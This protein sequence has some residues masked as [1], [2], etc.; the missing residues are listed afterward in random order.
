MNP[1]NEY[2]WKRIYA[3]PDVA[4]KD[5][6]RYLALQKLPMDN[7]TFFIDALNKYRGIRVD[8][9]NVNEDMKRQG[10][11]EMIPLFQTL[12]DINKAGQKDD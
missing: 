2:S 8:P 9:L 12:M 7:K 6:R 11:C 5:V 3:D 10:R 4:K 1:M